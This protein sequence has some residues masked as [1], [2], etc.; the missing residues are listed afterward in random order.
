[1][2][3]D[4]N[5]GLHFKESMSSTQRKKLDKEATYLPHNEESRKIVVPK[6]AE[7]NIKDT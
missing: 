6:F 3:M 7:L 2:Q 4:K 1:M 5:V